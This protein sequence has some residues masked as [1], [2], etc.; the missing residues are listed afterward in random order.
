MRWLFMWF[1]STPV[2]A[3]LF[4]VMPNTPVLDPGELVLDLA[5]THGHYF[6]IRRDEDR[7]YIPDLRWQA[8]F[9]SAAG[10]V[11]GNVWN[12]A[13]RIEAWGYPL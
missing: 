8:Q 12:S 4:F 9:P 6:I 2:W 3:N 1:L 7:T 10:V 5:V 11:R 13:F